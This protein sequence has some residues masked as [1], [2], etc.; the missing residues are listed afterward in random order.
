MSVG[1]SSNRN[2]LIAYLFMQQATGRFLV[3]L[4]MTIR[5]DP[6]YLG[7]PSEKGFLT[8]ESKESADTTTSDDNGIKTSS[9]DNF[10]LLE[11]NSPRYFDLNVEDEDANTGK[12]NEKDST[13]YFFSGVYRLLT[14]THKFANGFYSIDLRGAKETSI[15]LSQV[16]P[17]A[18]YSF[19]APDSDTL[20][21]RANEYEKTESDKDNVKS[22]SW[23]RGYITGDRAVAGVRKGAP[24]TLSELL[25]RKIITSEE[26]EAYRRAY[27]NG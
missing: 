26:A 10:F 1:Q 6:W 8:Q 17:N 7:H 19:E 5:G 14:A 12:W 23:I 25:E 16:T 27:P 2:S 20:R 15:D 21:N 13:S 3:D 24:V 11:I 22:P 18:D 9:A 4:D